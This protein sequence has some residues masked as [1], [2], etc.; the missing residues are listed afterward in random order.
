VKRK[1][2]LISFLLAGFVSLLAVGPALAFPPLPSSFYGTVMLNGA[3]VSDG[4]LVQA[5]ING[6][7]YAFGQTQTYRGDSVYGLD[8]PGDDSSTP[9]VIEGG[10]AG[11]TLQFKVG[12]VLAQ[13]TGTWHGGTN[14]ELN[15]TAFTSGPPAWT[16]EPSPTPSATPTPTV[17][18]TPAS[19]PTS[20][21]PG[22]SLPTRTASPQPAASTPTSRPSQATSPAPEPTQSVA[23][24]RPSPTTL[25]PAGPVGTAGAPGQP[26]ST[27]IPSPVTLESA[28]PAGQAGIMMQPTLLPAASA[29]AAR[30]PPARTIAST[31]S[32]AIRLD[33]ASP[34]GLVFIGAAGIVGALAMITLGVVGG[35]WFMDQRRRS[36]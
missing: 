17:Q 25:P 10:Q 23:S 35:M 8:I 12:A 9:G 32:G 15:L 28:T 7:V 33:K 26:S 18:P 16:P 21:P 27:V 5:L 24:P 30:L 4:T 1:S 29:V 14:D 13:E 6:Q 34:T 20:T 3:N 31:D 19:S 2:T 11:D 22:P 36:G